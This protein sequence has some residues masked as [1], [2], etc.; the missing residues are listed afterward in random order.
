MANHEF[1][2]SSDTVPDGI[3]GY[4]KA[5]GAAAA[6]LIALVADAIADGSITGAEWKTIAIAVVTAGFAAYALANKVAG[7]KPGVINPVPVVA[8]APP[9]E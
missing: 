1:T 7:L 9:A 3:F 8:D 5:I 2:S 6:P 4:S